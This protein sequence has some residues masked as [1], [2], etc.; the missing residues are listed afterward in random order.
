MENV[1][2]IQFSMW[3]NGRKMN[4]R[5]SIF[6]KTAQPTFYAGMPVVTDIS[7]FIAQVRSGPAY[8][9]TR[10]KDIT[11]C[12]DKLSDYLLQEL[13]TDPVKSLVQD[14]RGICPRCSSWVEEGTLGMVWVYSRD[15]DRKIVMSS[16]GPISR[17][18]DG[19]CA[20]SDCRSEEI[21]LIWRGSQ[22]IRQQV[23]DHLE[24]LRRAPEF[25]EYVALPK[26][27]DRLAK[28]DL[29]NY[30]VDTIEA[31]RWRQKQGG[32]VHLC[33][34]QRRGDCLIWVSVLA[35]ALENA[36]QHLP[37]EFVQQHMLATPGFDADCQAL[38][39]WIDA[40]DVLN[41]SLVPEKK[42]AEKDKFTITPA[43]LS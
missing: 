40:A 26:Y 32:D 38:F 14:F 17:L 19:H 10:I 16:N 43:E 4:L 22:P 42:L 33:N 8:L 7:A 30:A 36:K 6:R 11:L 37:G 35:M 21:I 41:L 20:N 29:L 2:F 18:R 39:H 13:H 1:G 9:R 5:S 27:L 3:E 24:R 25:K 15:K 23:L 31:F 34:G 12:V 28:P